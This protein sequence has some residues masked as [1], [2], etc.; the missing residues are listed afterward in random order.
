MK[1]ITLAGATLGLAAAC[2]WAG[3]E[4]IIKQRA[5]EL[6]DQNNVRQ[7]VP[8][9]TA[10]QPK[11]APNPAAV[12]P[13]PSQQNMG[14]LQTELAAIKPTAPATPEQKQRLS[15]LLV[16]MAEGPVKP[17]AAAADK[18]AEA[19]AGAQASN[20]MSAASRARL[21]QDLD[22]IINPSKYPQAKKDAIIA[23]VQAIFQAGGLP[24][25]R[26][27]AIAE[28]ARGLGPTGP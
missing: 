12:A 23:D 10:P 24:R 22:G 3:P 6:R 5:K 16:A 15:R 2:A 25:S 20:P 8:P 27:V 4:T 19:L 9:A 18:L 26:A 13:T 28:A 21:V 14:R 11:P 17:S 1:K 7:G